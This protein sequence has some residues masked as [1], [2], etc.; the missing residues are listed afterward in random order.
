MVDC[1][2]TYRRRDHRGG[3]LAICPR[4]WP[5]DRLWH[6]SPAPTNRQ[7]RLRLCRHFDELL[8]GLRRRRRTKRENS[9]NTRATQRSRRVALDPLAAWLARLAVRSR[10]YRWRR[11]RYFAVAGRG[12]RL[13]RQQQVRFIALP[14]IADPENDRRR[15]LAKQSPHPRRIGTPENREGTD[16]SAEGLQPPLFRIEVRERNAAVVLQDQ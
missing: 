11:R 1:S 16:I 2:V 9:A 7:S 13:L 5:S 10:N 15:V 6:Y 3:R 8:I 12:G 4:R 14:A